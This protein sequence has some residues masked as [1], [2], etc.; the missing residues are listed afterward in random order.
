MLHLRKDRATIRETGWVGES[1]ESRKTQNEAS[2]NARENKCCGTK[3]KA[4]FEVSFRE[5]VRRSRSCNFLFATQIYKVL[6][7]LLSQIP[8]RFF[9]C[10]TAY[11][12]TD[13][14]R[15]RCAI[16][17]YRPSRSKTFLAE[18]CAPR[19]TWTSKRQDREPKLLLL[20]F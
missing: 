6:W 5:D 13:A 16:N 17:N 2:K 19:E 10:G 7:L 15:S 20:P 18:D 14:P 4:L 1:E 12:T 3:Q 8:Y 11:G 9:V